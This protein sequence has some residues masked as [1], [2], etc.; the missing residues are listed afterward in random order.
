MLFVYHEVEWFNGLGHPAVVILHVY[1]FGL[2]HTC[3]DAWFREI[4]NQCLVFWQCLVGAEQLQ[5]TFFLFF[6]VVRAYQLFGF[7]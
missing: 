6:L 2:E 5:E 1:L 4:F 7:R 3:F